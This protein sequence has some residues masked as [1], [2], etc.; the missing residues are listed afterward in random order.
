[1]MIWKDWEGE[2]EAG[3]TLIDVTS[4]P[5]SD[6]GL[7]KFPRILRPYLVMLRDHRIQRAGLRACRLLAYFHTSVVLCQLWVHCCLV[8]PAVSPL[9]PVNHFE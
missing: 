9:E 8:F 6:D 2:T 1:M 5:A 4:F 7:S 3:V